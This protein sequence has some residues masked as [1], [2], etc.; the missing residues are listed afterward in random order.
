[1]PA[2]EKINKQNKIILDLL[3]TLLRLSVTVLN[4]GELNISICDKDDFG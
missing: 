1:M 3:F 2:R 4:S